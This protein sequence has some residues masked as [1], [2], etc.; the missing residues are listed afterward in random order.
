MYEESLCCFFSV[1]S[2]C[3]TGS[4]SAFVLLTQ[5]RNSREPGFRWRSGGKRDD[6]AGDAK[7]AGGPVPGRQACRPDR[8]RNSF[9]SSHRLLGQP[10]IRLSRAACN[11]GS[12]DREIEGAVYRLGDTLRSGRS[13]TSSIKRLKLDASGSLRLRRRRRRRG[14]GLFFSFPRGVCSR[15]LEALGVGLQALGVRSALGLHG[16]FLIGLRA[17]RGCKDG[18]GQNQKQKVFHYV[19]VME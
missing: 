2:I 1:L 8:Q 19:E 7:Q 5:R 9:R 10:A 11:S 3:R 18:Q 17:A 4:R 16:R 12:G 15:L 13:A 6:R 14:L